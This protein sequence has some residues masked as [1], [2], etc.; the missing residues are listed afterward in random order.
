M[1]TVWRNGAL[2]VNG[3]EGFIIDTRVASAGFD[4]EVN[5]ALGYI[6][7]TAT[8][9]D[10]LQ[11]LLL[12]MRGSGSKIAIVKGNGN[13]CASGGAALTKLAKALCHNQGDKGK[14]VAD[15]MRRCGHTDDWEWLAPLISTTPAYT[16]QGT[17]ETTGCGVA[18]LPIDIERW[19]DGTRPFGYPQSNADIETIKL[20]L[21]V[22]LKDGALAGDGAGS[23]VVWN[24]AKVSATNTNGVLLH[25]PPA[26]G[27]AH[28]LLHAWYNLV[29]QQLGVD[30]GH[31]ST[32]LFEY[33]CVGLGPWTGAGVNENSIRSEWANVLPH[34]PMT[35][36]PNRVNPARR[37]LY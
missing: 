25:R 37:D 26:V 22:I 14:A 17:P 10:L 18:V 2:H 4:A 36:A 31:F 6:Q 28:E 16:I 21:L 7:R 33:M 27:L 8:G 30:N 34:V 35:D 5:T 11:N 29:G 15:A 13:S 1:P 9:A 32:V 20:V 24:P 23:K 19:C 12:Q 3:G